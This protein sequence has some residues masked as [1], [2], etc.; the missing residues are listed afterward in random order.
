MKIDAVVE[1]SKNYETKIKLLEQR[2]AN[3]HCE[4]KDKQVFE[5]VN[6]MNPK[7]SKSRFCKIIL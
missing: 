4:N 1:Q 3:C 7:L 5:F 6:N 2:L